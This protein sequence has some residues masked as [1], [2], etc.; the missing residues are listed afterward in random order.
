MQ[1]RFALHSLKSPSTQDQ[2]DSMAKKA[3]KAKTKSAAKKPAAKKTAA[4]KTTK[5]K[6]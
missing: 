4:K 6:K 3:T 5:K 1:E 2:E